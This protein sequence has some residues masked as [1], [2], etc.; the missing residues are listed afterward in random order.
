MVQQSP[1]L[2]K[3]AAPTANNAMNTFRG[4]K[5]IAGASHES[6]SSEGGVAKFNCWL[7]HLARWRP[8]KLADKR[9][10]GG[11]RD[12]MGSDSSEKECGTGRATVDLQNTQ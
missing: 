5:E 1:I 8:M 9:I 4:D 2:I 6:G 11:W 10:A 12:M 3:Q 7:S